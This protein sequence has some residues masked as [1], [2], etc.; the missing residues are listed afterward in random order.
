MGSPK[1]INTFSLP[2]F[3]KF[4]NKLT[5]QN[6]RSQE[7][8]TTI[9]SS[10]ASTNVVGGSKDTDDPNLVSVRWQK[11]RSRKK[12]SEGKKPPF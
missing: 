6:N 11:I 5:M 7:K 10:P 9:S 8:T 3:T 2:T 4:P 1:N 12:R